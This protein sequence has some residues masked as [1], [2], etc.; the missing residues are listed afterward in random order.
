MIQNC[1]CN[2]APTLNF[3]EREREMNNKTRKKK[4]CLHMFIVIITQNYK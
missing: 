4:L 2:L 1:S 3:E